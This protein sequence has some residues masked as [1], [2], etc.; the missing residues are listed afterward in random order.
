MKR[1]INTVETERTEQVNQL[2][3]ELAAVA[4]ERDALKSAPHTEGSSSREQEL[5]SQLEALQK[6]KAALEAQLAASQATIA[7]AANSIPDAELAAKLVRGNQPWY[8]LLL[9]MVLGA[10]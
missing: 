7:A 1:R 3:A 8:P 5:T 4:T 9:T 10:C 6:E 2:R